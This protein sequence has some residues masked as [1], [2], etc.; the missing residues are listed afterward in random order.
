MSTTNIL[1]ANFTGTFNLGTVP[2]NNTLV[3]IILNHPAGFSVQAVATTGAAGELS[4]V[5]TTLL[6]QTF[7]FYADREYTLFVYNPATAEKLLVTDPDSEQGYCARI[8][9]TGCVDTPPATQN[10]S[11]GIAT[12]S[13]SCCDETTVNIVQ[14]SVSSSTAG[15]YVVDRSETVGTTTYTLSITGNTNDWRMKRTVI[16]N[17]SAASVITLATPENNAGI[18]SNDDAWNNR[19]T[20]TYA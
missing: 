10:L 4:A 14:S 1:P 2:V 9:F 5:A 12:Q 6:N 3:H 19:A 8:K 16:A 13:A 18:T 11:F 20:L 7:A 15:D 17:P